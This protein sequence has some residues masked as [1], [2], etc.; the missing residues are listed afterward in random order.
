MA[1]EKQENKISIELTPEVA[2]GHYS[3]LAMIAHSQTEFVLDFI[4]LMPGVDKGEVRT[5]AIIP[6]EHAKRLLNALQENVERYEKQYGKI[7]KPNEANSFPLN[8]G[9]TVGEA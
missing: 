3:N 7:K 1:S 4:Q 2:R 9:G 5:R 6:P 8:F